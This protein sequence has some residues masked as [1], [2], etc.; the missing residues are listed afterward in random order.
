MYIQKMKKSFKFYHK[1][2]A[3]YKSGDYKGAITDFDNEINNYSEHPYTFVYRGRA[4]YHLGDKNGALED[5]I[6]AAELGHRDVYEFIE[7][8]FS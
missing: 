5:W 2:V 3:K 6:K 8:H 7:K 1:G 4:R